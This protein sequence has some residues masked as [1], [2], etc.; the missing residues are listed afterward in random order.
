MV[1]LKIQ[2]VFTHRDVSIQRWKNHHPWYSGSALEMRKMHCFLIVVLFF[3][4]VN[5]VRSSKQL[6]PA[7]IQ[8]EGKR[9]RG[10]GPRWAQTVTNPCP[11]KWVISITSHGSRIRSCRTDLQGFFFTA[12]HFITGLNHK[13]NT[14]RSQRLRL[15]RLICTEGF[16]RGVFAS[17]YHPHRWKM[18]FCL[19]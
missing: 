10:W 9:R 18:T 17:E 4:Q 7:T 6:L 13:A 1:H 5:F 15:T 2:T 8:G 16:D 11:R 19:E 3:T 14:G 12:W